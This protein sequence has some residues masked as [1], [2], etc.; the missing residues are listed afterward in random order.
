MFDIDDDLSLKTDIAMI[1]LCMDDALE[2]DEDLNKSR[3]ELKHLLKRLDYLI[4][5]S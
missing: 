5:E 3:D 4:A 1:L 2:F